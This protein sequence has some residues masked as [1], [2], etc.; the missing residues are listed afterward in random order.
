MPRGVGRSRDAEAGRVRDQVQPPPRRPG[1][2]PSRLRVRFPGK[3]GGVIQT[4]Q[5]AQRSSVMP[6]LPHAPSPR[7]RPPTSPETQR[8]CWGCWGGAARPP[9]RGCSPGSAGASKGVL[10]PAFTHPG[11]P[12]CI[13]IIFLKSSTSHHLLLRIDIFSLFVKKKKKNGGCLV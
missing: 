4:R 13:F 5:P 6:R 8:G 9:P 7:A 12:L 2:A 1:A 10:P 3:I 11:A